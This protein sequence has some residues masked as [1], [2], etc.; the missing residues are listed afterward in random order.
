M[1]ETSGEDVEAGD[2]RSVVQGVPVGL[3]EVRWDG[4]DGVLVGGNRVGQGLDRP[5]GFREAFAQAR[6]E[7]FFAAV[8]EGARAPTGPQIAIVEPA[9]GAIGAVETRAA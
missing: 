6:A 2:V 9:L 4:D 5:G 7:P 3:A 8:R 1:S